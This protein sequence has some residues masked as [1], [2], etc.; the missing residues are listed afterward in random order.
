M[1][2]TKS[3]S[4]SELTGHVS[5]GFVPKGPNQKVPI[6]HYAT[7]V[8][9]SLVHLSKSCLRAKLDCYTHFLTTTVC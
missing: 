3:E 7:Q 6:I 5:V 8:H 1:S 2:N 4:V 9:E